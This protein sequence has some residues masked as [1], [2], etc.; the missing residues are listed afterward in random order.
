MST[1]QIAISVIL[2]IYTDFEAHCTGQQVSKCC[3]VTKEALQAMRKNHGIAFSPFAQKHIQQQQVLRNRGYRWSLILVVLFL[4]TIAALES[5]YK[6]DLPPSIH[7]FAK[8]IGVRS[9]T[10]SASWS[11]E[12]YPFIHLAKPK[13]KKEMKLS[14]HGFSRFCS[15]KVIFVVVALIMHIS[16]TFKETGQPWRDY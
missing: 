13:G 5:M 9:M 7:G 12:Q 15:S 16:A 3:R 8:Y 6:K 4:H 2:Y 1:L 10:Y 14:F 11:T